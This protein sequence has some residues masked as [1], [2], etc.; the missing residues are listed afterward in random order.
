MIN[1]EYK[2]KIGKELDD[3]IGREFDKY[4][5]QNGVTCNYQSFHF[6]STY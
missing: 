2:K 3:F 6:V 4:A 5:I 1:I